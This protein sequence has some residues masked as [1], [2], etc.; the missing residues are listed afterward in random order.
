MFRLFSPLRAAVPAARLQSLRQEI[1]SSSWLHNDS[2]LLEDANAAAQKAIA[3]LPSLTGETRA[4]TE[5]ATADLLNTIKTSENVEGLYEAI[6][7]TELALG[8]ELGRFG[9]NVHRVPELQARVEKL[10][11]DYKNLMARISSDETVYRK[12]ERELG[13]SMLQLKSQ[14]HDPEYRHRV[15]DEFR[16]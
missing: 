11:E 9:D 5:R 6:Y 7:S 1:L 2:F 16:T 13:I 15:R 10:M 14:I 3:S 8:D 12:V 4:E